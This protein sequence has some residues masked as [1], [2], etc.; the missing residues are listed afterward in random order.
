M[1]RYE[2]IRNEIDQ[3][4]KELRKLRSETGT[5]RI[6]GSLKELSMKND[7]IKDAITSISTAINAN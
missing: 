1:N 4:E 3:I 7:Q 6:E 2:R 5:K